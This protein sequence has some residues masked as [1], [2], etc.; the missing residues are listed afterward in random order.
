MST[1]PSQTTADILDAARHL[2]NG[3]ALIIPEVS[4][5]DYESLLEGF[6]ERPGLRVSYDRGRLEIVSPR[7]E[8]GFYE[9]LVE[10][11]VTIACQILRL[12]LEKCAN[13]TWKRRRLAR[14]I[15]ADA[16]YYIQNAEK[17][18]GLLKVDVEFLPPPDLAVE[19]DVTSSSADKFGIYAAL[20]VQELWVYDGKICQIYEL[21]GA[22][23]VE[24]PVSRSIPGLTGQL[25]AEAL[26][27]SK[28]EGQDKARSWFRRKIQKIARD[29]R[30][31][32]K[33]R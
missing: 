16:S 29:M 31:R 27:L 14:G 11:L 6:A 18:I 21:K 1:M 2:P 4:W 8:H 3:A 20:R 17:V 30:K 33:L 7:R 5:E 28:T 26:E 13:T 32:K 12:K 19:I 25:I 22:R 10:D 23:H 9:G 15:E 24:I